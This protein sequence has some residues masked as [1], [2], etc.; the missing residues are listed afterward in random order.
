VPGDAKH[1]RGVCH[2][3]RVAYCPEPRQCL[4][5]Q[6]NGLRK[7]T[8]AVCLDAE[9][10]HRPGQPPR[11]AH[12]P[13]ESRCLRRM[14]RCFRTGSSLAGRTRKEEP[15]VGF[16]DLIAL[17]PRECQEFLR[18]G[19]CPDVVALLHGEI[20]RAAQRT[21]LRFG[22]RV[23]A[24]G[25]RLLQP[26]APLLALGTHMPVPIERPSQ[27]RKGFGITARCEPAERGAQIAMLYRELTQAS[28]LTC[29]MDKRRHGDSEREIPLS[30]PLANGLVFPAGSHLLEAELTGRLQHAEPRLAAEAGFLVKQALVDEGG[31]PF[32][33]INSP[34]VESGSGCFGRCQ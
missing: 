20:A 27:A 33:G 31:N 22:R 8:S 3:E 10:L 17:R 30:V 4:G 24:R 9:A 19:R 28:R 14:G 34:V 11:I 7:V 5:E 6:R 32:K 1:V 29:Q 16:G 26:H 12:H 2:P 13:I 23:G 25:E 21:H 18:E 15:R